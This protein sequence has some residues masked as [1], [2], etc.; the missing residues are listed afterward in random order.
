MAGDNVTLYGLEVDGGGTKNCVLLGAGGQDN[1][2]LVANDDTLDH[3]RL[4]GCGDDSHE[5]AVYA[6]FTRNLHITDSYM[7]SSGGYG[8]QFYPDSDDT[9][10][11]HSVLDGNDVGTGY[12]GDVTFASGDNEYQQGTKSE[13]D[14]IQTSLLTFVSPGGNT[15]IITT[16]WPGWGGVGT[17]H[18]IRDSCVWSP[19]DAEL[20]GDGSFPLLVNI[21]RQDPM[22]TDRAAGDYTLQPGSPCAG[23][24]PR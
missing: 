20:G 23:M 14:T 22:Y 12:G 15:Q 21:V 1:P 16:Y 2:L 7:L 5:H 4:H 19:G 18:V 6:E 24:G 3:V 11:E 17:G 8:I 9:L 10:V 13:R